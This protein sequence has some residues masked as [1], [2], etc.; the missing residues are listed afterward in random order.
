MVIQSI[1]ADRHEKGCN[2][3][4]PG[5]LHVCHVNSGATGPWTF[6][7]C[8]RHNISYTKHIPHVL[9]HTCPSHFS[10]ISI[11]TYV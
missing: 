4:A 3:P 9:Y 10:T 1:P 2:L 6:F 7:W 5:K 11:E 8:F